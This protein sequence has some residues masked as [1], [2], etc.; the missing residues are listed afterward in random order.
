MSAQ[1]RRIERMR[2]V[3]TAKVREVDD[4]E[5]FC[6]VHEVWQIEAGDIVPNYHIRVDLLE[7]LRTILTIV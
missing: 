6:A 3:E 5:V 4:L 2:T 1:R 7:E